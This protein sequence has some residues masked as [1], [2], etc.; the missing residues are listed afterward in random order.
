MMS[1]RQKLTILFRLTAIISILIGSS[2]CIKACYAEEVA[3]AVARLT[4]LNADTAVNA[5]VQNADCGYESDGVIVAGTEDIELY[6]TGTITRSIDE[7]TIEIPAEGY[8]TDINCDTLA[9]TKAFGTVTF[10][11]VVQ[12]LEVFSTGLATAPFIPTGP[13]VVDMEFEEV[14]FTNFRADLSD[15]D[16]AMIMESAA[17]SGIMYPR[18][19]VGGT[20]PGICSEQSDHV[21]FE[22]AFTQVSD[23]RIQAYEEGTRTIDREIELQV[24]SADLTGVKGR[25]H[26]DPQAEGFRE[27]AIAG[28]ITVWDDESFTLPITDIED[29]NGGLD[30]DYN[31]EDFENGMF[32]QVDADE[33]PVFTN[34]IDYECPQGN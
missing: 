14:T 26:E 27:N 15:K 23:L 32:C 3:M 16:S 24:Q 21:S 33:N 28:P 4:V 13:D 29:D 31:L 25:T 7:C 10:R 1:V 8:T 20:T 9:E 12:T 6:T 17:L 18:M 2:A 11:N 5:F 22:V 19:A 34:P 30:P